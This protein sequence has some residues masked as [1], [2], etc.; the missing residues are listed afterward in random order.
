MKRFFLSVV[1]IAFVYTVAAA[2]ELT[3]QSIYAP[4]GLTGRAPDTIQW[5][6]DGKK[7]SY[8]LHQEQGEKA[9]LY[10]IDVTSGK[11]AVLVA[12]EKIA[13]MKPPVT[14]SKDDREKDN[15][16]RYHVAGYH[17]APDSEHILFDA[18]GQLWYYTLSTGKYVPLS[19]QGESAVDPRFSADGKQLS[20]VRKHNLVVKPVSGGGEKALTNDTDENLLN[21]EVDWVYSEELEVRSNYFW[22]PHS[23]KIV[24]MQMNETKVPTY[25]ITDYIP[26]HPTV[27][28]EKYPKVGD[29]NPEVRLGVVN[30]GGGSIKWIHLTDEKDM[31]IP[32]F[33][34]VRDG[35]IWA[36]VLNRAQNQLDLYFVD[37]A[38]GKSRRVMS[39][40]SDTWIET[41]DNF[42][43]LKSAD[44]FIWPSW[45]DGHTHLYLYSFDKANPLAADARLVNQITKGDFEVFDT[46][47]VDDA[48]GTVY[49]TTNA[50]DARQRVL[51]S[52]KLDGSDFQV[53]AKGGTHQA[54]LAPNSKYYVD[55]YSAIM[56]PPQLSF[57]TV[58][59]SCNT[60]WQSRSVDPYKLVPPQFVDF[61]AED[62]T[63][64]HGIIY[65]PPDSAGKK[66]P[67]LNNPYGGP[68]G[69]T[70]RDE[71]GG[72]NFLFNEI[73]L[74]DGIAVLQVDNRGMGA[75]GKKFAAALMHNFGEVEIKDQLDSIDQALAKFPQLDGSRMGWWGWSY[76]GYMTLMAMTHSDRFKAGIAVAPV[77]DW[78]D[79]DS[80]YTERYGGLIP[81]FD[82]AYKKGSPLTYAANLKGHL[83][84]VHGTSDDNVHMQN[85]MQMAYALINAGKQF[86]LMIYPR[87]THSISGPGTRVHLFTRIQ[88]FFQHELLGTE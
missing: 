74:R 2:Q 11:P 9:D 79:Y 50:G 1:L 3:I 70:V 67:L 54:T 36:T 42:Q 34:W 76:G 19:G 82:G 85:T 21:G 62:G 51:C 73:L 80:I 41:D 20:Y 25:P 45:R 72:A 44:K 14:G 88:S 49:V 56:T 71:W 40:K 69:Q 16:A 31:Y 8:F 64:L 66:I 4:N 35:V 15:R 7:V 77:T 61:K 83:L 5:S 63:V 18:N 26:Q 6:P 86:D 43:I 60:F 48:T 38:S 24:F 17:W 75:R 12:S 87:K 29:P 81:Q 46:N 27:Y 55:H 13:A 58:G 22:S 59:G 53:L 47:G 30:A 39:E 28:Q 57:C 33:G 23:S 68:H 32:R 65:L 84:E 10:Y 52:V 78:R 37:A